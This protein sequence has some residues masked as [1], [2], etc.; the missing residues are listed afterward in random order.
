MHDHSANPYTSPIHHSAAESTLEGNDLNDDFSATEPT[1]IVKAA[2]YTLVGAGLLVN[3]SGIQL[4][5]FASFVESWM[6]SLPLL[7]ILLGFA[8]MLLGH[9]ITQ[10]RGWAMIGGLILSGILFIGM[11]AWVF[12]ALSS[13]SFSLIAMLTPLATLASIILAV[14][15]IGPCMRASAARERLQKADIDLN[16]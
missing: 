8:E 11:S 13:G 7:M 6:N 15:A 16:F 1:K 10:T 12:V 3:L 5:L 2:G 4:V 14:M 9:K